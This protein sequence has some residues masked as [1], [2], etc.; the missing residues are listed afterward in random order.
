[1]QRVKNNRY[2]ILIQ[3]PLQEPKLDITRSKTYKNWYNKISMS[4]T[5]ETILYKYGS[6]HTSI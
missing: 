2:E 3:K 6:K 1:M 5:I 4:S